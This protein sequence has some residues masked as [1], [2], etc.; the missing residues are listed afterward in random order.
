MELILFDKINIALIIIAFLNFGLGTLIYL[1]G[2]Q[3]KVNLVYTFNIITIIGWILAMVLYRSAGPKES[4]FWCKILYIS[5]TF[6]ASSFL[7]FTYIFPSQIRKISLLEKI[8]ICAGNIIII[9]LI[10]IPNLIIKNILIHPGSEKEIIFGPGY[11]FYVIY[12]ILYFSLGFWK[13]FKKY[14]KSHSIEKNQIIYLMSGYIISTNLALVTNLFMPWF[15]RFELN[16]LGQILTLFMVSFTVYA[17]LKYRLMDIRVTI[18]KSTI[19][20]VLVLIVTIGYIF[21]VYLLTWLVFHKDIPPLKELILTGLLMGVLVTIGFQP[22]YKFLQN[23]TDKYLF[24]GEYHPQELIRNITEKLAITL[25]IEKIALILTKELGRQMKL[26]GGK[27]IL[28]K[29]N[30]PHP[31]LKNLIKYLQ[32]NKE[33]L[34]T[35]E[36]QREYEDTHRFDQRYLAY[37]DLQKSKQ[38]L[39]VPIYQKAP[40][41]KTDSEKK[42]QEKG[43]LTALLFF[44]NKKSDEAFTNQDIQTLEIIAV[45][46]GVALENAKMYEEMKDFSKTLQKE[47]EKQTK[48]LREANIRLQQL[49]KAK[50]EFI[51]IASHQLR[52]PLTVIKGLISM[53]LEEFWGPLNPGL[54]EHLEKVYQSGERLLRLIEDLLNISRI[55]A[56]R[57][58][59]DFQPISLEKI[60]REIT[61]ELLPEAKKKKLYLRFIQP[62]KPLPKVMADPLKIRQVIQNLI[63]NA[64]KYTSR[65][66]ATVRLYQKRN[67]VIFCVRDTGLGIEPNQ[68]KNLFEKFQR[69]KRAVRHHTEGT[70][71]GLYLA[72]KIIEAHHGKIWVESKGLNQGSAFY[73]SLPVITTPIETE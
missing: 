14:L 9:A 61:E 1:K 62:K 64:I 13:L 11:I 51:S 10:L 60:T 20:S 7:Y 73:F 69:G 49:D 33:I 39:V 22:L 40:P 25:E 70:G 31:E 41:K 42:H 29:S 18:K 65:G 46:A 48:E 32:L 6:I 34:V 12:I 47:V 23:I 66:G 8:L 3:R 19:F 43:K 50:S 38:A 35:E 72:A 37:K 68:Q 52:T 15:G 27:F 24:K 58:E 21:A 57:M 36:L 67:R 71:L 5:P 17:I 2:R 56:G 26:K 16:W 63:D 53:A 55:E 44:G 54:K 59:F 4:I 45:Q 28:L 30:H